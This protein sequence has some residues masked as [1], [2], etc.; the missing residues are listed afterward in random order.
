M[1]KKFPSDFDAENSPSPNTWVM[2]CDDNTSEPK[3]TQARNLKSG[4]PEASTDGNVFMRSNSQWIN[5]REWSRTWLLNKIG[6]LNI[7]SAQHR[8]ELEKDAHALGYDKAIGGMLVQQGNYT[9]IQGPGGWDG[10]YYVYIDATKSP[11]PITVIHMNHAKAELPDNISS[12]R[13]LGSF[14][15]EAGKITGIAMYTNDVKVDG[16]YIFDAGSDSSL[17]SEAIWV[18]EVRGGMN[19]RTASNDINIAV[20]SILVGG[21]Y[22]DIPAHVVQWE[23]GNQYDYTNATYFVLLHLDKTTPA[24][25]RFICISRAVLYVKPANLESIPI[26]AFDYGTGT[27]INGFSFRND[28]FINGASPYGSGSGG[29]IPEAPTDGQYYARRNEGWAVAP[30]GSGGSNNV[31]IES[32]FPARLHG[33]KILTAGQYAGGVNT[34]ASYK[35]TDFIPCADAKSITITGNTVSGTF[36]CAFYTNQKRF[37]SALSSGTGGHVTQTISSVPAGATFIRCNALV[38]QLDAKV[39]ID[40]GPLISRLNDIRPETYFLGSIR[41][42][43]V[44]FGSSYPG[45]NITV[46]YPPDPEAGTLLYKKGSTLEAITFGDAT[47]LA[48]NDG[49]YVL[50]I[51]IDAFYAPEIKLST[52]SEFNYLNSHYGATVSIFDKIVVGVFEAVVNSAPNQPYVLRHNFPGNIFNNQ[53]QL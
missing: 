15:Y 1:G 50:W 23:K 24:N 12:P 53:T 28:I 25:S 35:C 7:N 8:L 18:S 21:K 48:T 14:I 19:I 42:T 45:V 31:T 20:G 3:K 46:G 33:Y 29:G 47:L 26:G 49:I 44:P 22:Y 27:T 6:T 38:T 9:W 4:I 16:Q 51:A 11:S 36:L 13:L 41:A 40:H 10:L 2:I 39:T 30:S 17:A 37:L 43:T 32:A 52:I 5:A 34:D